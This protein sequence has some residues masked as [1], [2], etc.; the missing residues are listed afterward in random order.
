MGVGLGQYSEDVWVLLENA[1]P[2]VSLHNFYLTLLLKGGVILTVLYGWYV[3]NLGSTF[4]KLRKDVAPRVHAI[5]PL[6]LAILA[7]MLA[8]QIAFNISEDLMLF[9]G[10]LL[11][12]VLANIRE[13]G[14]GIQSP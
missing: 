10:V 13:D 2:G 5:F 14:Q 12:L 4:V 11:A 1:P 6:G 3:L 9:T 8:F 7:G